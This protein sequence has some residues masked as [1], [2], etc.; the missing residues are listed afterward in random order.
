MVT[1]E[2]EAASHQE[3]DRNSNIK[4]K[5]SKRLVMLIYFRNSRVL[6]RPFQHSG[7]PC[8]L[9]VQYRSQVTWQTSAS[10]EVATREGMDIARGCRMRPQCVHVRARTR[11][12]ACARVLA[13][14]RR[15]RGPMRAYDTFYECLW[16]CWAKRGSKR[17][18]RDRQASNSPHFPHRVLSTLTH[19]RESLHTRMHKTFCEH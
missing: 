8:L 11:T 4:W 3:E 5:R 7:P 19:D 9:H 2:E 6:P 14:V 10:S 16:V 1:R 15:R 13:R 18:A 12:R 17:T